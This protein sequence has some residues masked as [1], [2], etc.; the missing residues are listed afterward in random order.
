M[1]AESAKPIT[2]RHFTDS[3][4]CRIV[5]HINFCSSHLRQ[6]H[7]HIQISDYG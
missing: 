3:D 4:A 2:D 1:G 5:N 6:N 7:E